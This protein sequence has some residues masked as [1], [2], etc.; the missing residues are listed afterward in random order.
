MTKKSRAMANTIKKVKI[1]LLIIIPAAFLML[2][3]TIIYV[4]RSGTSH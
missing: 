2:I 1:A 3:G 4:I